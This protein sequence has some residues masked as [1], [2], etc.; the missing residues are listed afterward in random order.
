MRQSLSRQRG[1]TLIELMVAVFITAIL[2]AIGYGAVNQAV[3]NRDSLDEQQNRL[4]MIQSMMR[5]IAQDVNQLSL[6]PIRDPSGNDWLP[7]LVATGSNQQR[8]VELTR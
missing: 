4:I 2:F 6:R 1:F 3:K 5:T 8:I 7:V